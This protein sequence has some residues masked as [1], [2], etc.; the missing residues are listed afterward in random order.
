MERKLKRKVSHFRDSVL[1]SKRKRQTLGLLLD[2]LSRPEIDIPAI[3]HH[4]TLVLTQLQQQKMMIVPKIRNLVKKQNE[5]LVLE[6]RQNNKKVNSV[7]NEDKPQERR[8]MESEI[9]CQSI[10]GPSSSA[11]EAGHE[12]FLTFHAGTDEDI[13]VGLP[14][15]GRQNISSL[16]LE[17]ID[18]PT[19]D[20]AESFTVG[21]KQFEIIFADSTHPAEEDVFSD[22]DNEHND[23]TDHSTNE[24]VQSALFDQTE[25]VNVPS[26]FPLFQLVHAGEVSEEIQREIEQKIRQANPG[27]NLNSIT[28]KFKSPETVEII[29]NMNP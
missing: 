1:S 23:A 26:S 2:E 28:F 24:T 20:F 3:S 9:P 17:E 11:A 6:I 21:E 15:G 25:T 18:M 4:T 12:E 8:N 29:A 7:I 14:A 10:A 27:L 22:D 19:T 5:P 13:P 16:S